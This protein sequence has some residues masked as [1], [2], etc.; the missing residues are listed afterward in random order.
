MPKQPQ[1]TN[2]QCQVIT[3][4][5]TLDTVDFDEA[6]REATSIAYGC[7]GQEVRIISPGHAVLVLFATSDGGLTGRRE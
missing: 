4:D 3:A 2:E 7:I 6:F 5:C 1:P